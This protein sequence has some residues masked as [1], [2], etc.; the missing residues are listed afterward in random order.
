MLAGCLALWETAVRAAGVAPYVL[1][2]PSRIAQALPDAAPALARHAVTT[3]AEATVGL[4]AGTIA[5]VLLAT[6]VGLVPLAHRMLHPLVVV[7]QT[8]PTIVLAPLLIIWTGFGMLPKVIVVALTVFFPVLVSTATALRVGDSD[9]LD[10]ARGLGASNSQLVGLVRLPAVLPAAFAGV[11]IGATYAVGA[12]V[13]GEYMAAESGLGVYIL[14]SR[15]A[16]AVDQIFLAV[17]VIA[18]L[19]AALFRIIDRLAGALMPWQA[20]AVMEVTS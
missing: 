20:P 10:M 14:R 6:L 12:A 8:V 9:L 1:P 17:A 2:A 18:V 7:T 16:F 4:V 11:R 5:G 13:V 15:E 3:A 19:T